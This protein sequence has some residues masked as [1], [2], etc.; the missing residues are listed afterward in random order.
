MA[1]SRS[2]GARFFSSS[3]AWADNNHN[4]GRIPA[5]F[6]VAEHGDGPRAR[7]RARTPPE[8]NTIHQRSNSN[9]NNNDP[10][11]ALAASPIT[12]IP[13]CQITAPPSLHNRQDQGQIQALSDQLQQVSSSFRSV[14]QAS[15]Q[16]SQSSQQLSQSLQQATQRLSQTEQALA[17]ARAGQDAAEQASRAATQA[18]QD[19]S[20]SIGQIQASADRAVSSAVSSASAAIAANMASVTSAVGASVASAVAAASM[21]AAGV[22]NSAASLVRQA[23]AEATAVRTEANSQVQQAQGAAVS[24]TQAALAVVGGVV[25][26]SLLTIAAFVLVARYKKRAQQ[27][28]TPRFAVRGSISKS[29]PSFNNTAPA[30]AVSGALPYKLSDYDA[31]SNYDNGDNRPSTPPSMN[32]N[33]YPV[34]V[35]APGPALL[36]QSNSAG[37]AAGVGIATSYYSP[38]IGARN[39]TGDGRAGVFQLKDPPRGG[40]GAGKFALFPKSRGDLLVSPLSQRANTPSPSALST[41]G[42]KVPSLDT[43]LRAGTT[44]SPFGTL[45]KGE[46]GPGEE[47]TGWAI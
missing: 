27:R 45:Q 9:T 28:R 39:M 14:S 32:A 4:N 19:A 36:A 2:G 11:I 29:N 35:K 3:C 12:A 42:S 16:V 47:K 34:D 10:I 31:E 1:G 33:R 43:W 30:A 22:M 38:G 8:E 26:S 7:A 15:Q 6:N 17:S 21:S 13:Q 44:V 46:K 23:Q 25:G 18:A 24:V 40:G 5:R 20:R 41:G 37:S